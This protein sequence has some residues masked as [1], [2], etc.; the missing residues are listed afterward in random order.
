M[1]IG[2]ISDTHGDPTAWDAAMRVLGPVDL[3]THAGDVLYH[4]I[5][6]PITETY[7]PRH[8][9]EILNGLTTPMVHA[10]GNCDS[11][12]DQ[13]AL[14]NH[15]LSD[16][17]WVSHEGVRILVTHGHKYPEEDLVLMAHRAGAQ[18][19]HVGHTHVPVIKDMDHVVVFNAGSCAVPK[20]EGGFATVGLLE[21]GKLYV[22]DVRTGERYL[23]G[24]LP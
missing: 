23:E 7:R 15:I 5:F 18:V 1:R 3:I 2:L 22:L 14:D 12:V 24:E 17:A 10:R 6:N 9:A 16:F 13:L 8:L 19:L 4:G 21:D 20:Q 11:E